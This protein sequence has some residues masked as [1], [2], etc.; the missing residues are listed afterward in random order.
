VVAA[1]A[2]VALMFS[3]ALSL[4]TAQERV[5]TAMQAGAPSVKRWGGR[6]LVVVGAWFIVLAV[7]ASFFARVFPV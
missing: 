7:F 1:L 4:A 6:I 3:L 5:V 2:I